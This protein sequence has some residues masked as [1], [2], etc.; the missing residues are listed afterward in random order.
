MKIFDFQLICSKIFSSIKLK[1]TYLM[2][3]KKLLH[4]K[5]KMSD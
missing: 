4:F 3:L 5:Q 1:L 2:C